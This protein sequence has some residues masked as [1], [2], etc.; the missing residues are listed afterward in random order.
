MAMDY[1]SLHALTAREL[2]AAL[3]RDVFI[4][5]AKPVLTSVTAIRT[6]GEPP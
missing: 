4:L 2:I 1:R 5:S 6:A 3:T